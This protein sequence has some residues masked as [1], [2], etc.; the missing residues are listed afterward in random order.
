MKKI[1][2]F[3]AAIFFAVQ[4][5][6]AQQVTVEGLGMD[7]ESALRDAK[8]NAVEQVIGT[9]VDSRTLVGNAMVEM[10]SIYTKAQGFAREVRVLEEGLSGG[11][12]RVQA[13]FDVSGS[14]D[15]ELLRQVRAVVELN[16]PR[17]AIMVSPEGQPGVHEEIVEAAMEDR[18]I[19]LG[20]SHVVDAKITAGL[21]DARMLESLY[22]GTPISGVGSSYGADFVVIGKS[23]AS[24]NRISIPD[25]KGNY[26]ETML[27]TGRTEM[28][29]KIIR[30]DTGDILETFTV[31]S[32]GVENSTDFAEREAMKNMAVQAAAKVEEK[33]R[34]IGARSGSSVQIIAASYDNG[35]IQK[36]V[37]DL[38][39]LSGVE[40]VLLRE[41][42]DGKAILELDTAQDA[43]TII[44]ML[45]Q[46]TRLGIY[47]DE[48]SRS[49]AQIIVS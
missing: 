38:R 45:E 48:L 17:I 5:V 14:A 35:K 7:R 41:Y 40:N 22:N 26:K 20:F 21:Q 3:L 12:Y 18:L 9:F 6:N 43:N 19:S 33:F 10:D 49:R 23:R 30:L 47:V 28:T 34:R 25:F 42:R 16:D 44:R 32:K 13:V 1:F 15:S 24:A 8:R 11:A 36:L 29:A 27:H 4:P 46:K 37:E 31:E 39:S 2:L